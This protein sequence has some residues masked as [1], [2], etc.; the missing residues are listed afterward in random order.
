MK[1][2]VTLDAK[3]YNDFQHR[4]KRQAVRAIIKRNGR[5]ALVKSK[6]M[7]HYKFPGGGIEEN[8]SHIDA[9]V[10][11]VREETGLIVKVDTVKECGM[12]HE[13]RK[14]T[15]NDDI[16]EQFSYYYYLDVEDYFLEPALDE[17]E[18]K[19][20]YVLEWV[21]PKKAYDVNR[22]LAKDYTNKFLLR[23]V[24]MLRMLIDIRLVNITSLQSTE[25]YKVKRNSDMY[26]GRV[27]DIID[28]YNDVYKDYSDLYGVYYGNN[29]IGLVVLSNQLINGKWSFNDLIIGDD[30]QNQGFGELST[31]LI[32]EYFKK[33][34][35][36]NIIK[37]EVFKE[38]IRAIRCYEK[39]GFTITKKC[40]WD[41]NFL[42]MEINL[43]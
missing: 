43:I 29:I 5:I 17:N 6:V 15:I 36:S 33:K 39:C 27:E 2:L 11:E 16:F 13:I 20:Q 7:N 26:V 35:N 3:N 18:S 23:E 31:Y 21:N 34:G 32:I 38:N 37:I 24:Y 12:I 19:L 14:S 4:S 9:L 30:Y 1:T 10:R 41:S 25:P 28:D 40:E 22:E 8:E 42:E